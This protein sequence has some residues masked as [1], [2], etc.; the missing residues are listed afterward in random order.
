MP[1]V[2]QTTTT[3]SGNTNTKWWSGLINLQSL[4]VI[5]AGLTSLVTFWNTQKN[6]SGHLDQ[7]DK[8]VE[9]KADDADLNALIERV[10]RQYESNNK[11]LDRIISLEKQSEYEKGV[12][13]GLESK[14]VNK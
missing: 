7:L 2:T 13:D 1:T 9:R 4:V 8:T 5:G 10:N 12:H 11:I 14:Q 3:G 6:H